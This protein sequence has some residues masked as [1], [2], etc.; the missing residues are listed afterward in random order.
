MREIGLLFCSYVTHILSEID[1]PTKRDVPGIID[2]P[3]VLPNTYSMFS[4]VANPN[5]PICH[6]IAVEEK[7]TEIICQNDL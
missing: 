3:S 5:A 6:V 1:S 7:S 4:A 2:A